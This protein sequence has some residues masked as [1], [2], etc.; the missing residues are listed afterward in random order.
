MKI[1]KLFAVLDLI[2]DNMR[3]KLYLVFYEHSAQS[4]YPI[5]KRNL[6][7][8]QQFRLRKFCPI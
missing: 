6:I 7:D 5:G 1:R 8:V 2:S 3:D 4:D